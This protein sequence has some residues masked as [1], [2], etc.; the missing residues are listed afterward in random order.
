MRQATAIMNLEIR[1]HEHSL[2]VEFLESLVTVESFDILM[3][4]V[5]HSLTSVVFLYFT[6]I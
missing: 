6:E 3:V 2:T 4:L 5:E 1:S